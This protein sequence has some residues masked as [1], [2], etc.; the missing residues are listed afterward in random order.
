MSIG[1]FIVRATQNNEN[2]VTALLH[3]MMEV[4]YVRTIIL[5]ALLPQ[6]I[7][8]EVIER[9]AFTDISSQRLMEG[10][11]IPDLSIE[12]EQCLFIIENK[13]E[14]ARGFEDNQLTNY[15]KRVNESTKTHKAMIYLLPRL[16][17]YEH[18]LQ[19]LPGTCMHIVRWPDFIRSIELSGIE[20]D[21]PV[22]H[23]LLD[24]LRKRLSLTTVTA[25]EK[26]DLVTMFS[27]QKVTEVLEFLYKWK[28]F[29]GDVDRL[30]ISDDTLDGTYAKSALSDWDDYALGLFV[31]DQKNEYVFW[32]GY[33]PRVC[34]ENT[35]IFCCVERSL[36]DSWHANKVPSGDQ[37]AYT[38]V[39]KDSTY[40]KG[41]SCPSDPD[42]IYFPVDSQFLSYDAMAQ[43]V[44][45]FADIVK[46][47]ILTFL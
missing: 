23:Q 9:I 15:P 28:S 17:A 19:S 27:P 35:N 38:K 7:P 20:A 41:Y 12:N 1:Q 33:D 3:S 18:T 46:H 30:L 31:L 45:E 24:Y 21:N 42:W 4:P 2:T 37:E 6:D 10:V 44:K 16:Y 39:R 25:F 36:V 5:R 34:F 26:G 47:L 29:I 32:F 8:Y 40:L 11:G 14:G 22:V 43:S 13:I